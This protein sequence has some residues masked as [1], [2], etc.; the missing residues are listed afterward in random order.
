MVPFGFFL[1]SSKTEVSAVYFNP[2]AT[3][4]KLFADPFRNGHEKERVF[5]QWYM[6]STGTLHV[7]EAH[8]SN[9]R[10]TLAD[11]GYLFMNAHARHAIDPEPF[12]KQ[13]VAICTFKSDTRTLVSRTPTPFLKTRI[14][15]GVIP[16]D[17]PSDLL[18]KG[19]A[20]H[21]AE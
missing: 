15:L 10:E 18:V 8:P 21:N 6:V 17:Y 16:D 13:G 3:T 1:D 4:S 9:Y 19:K 2:R 12:F 7:N 5:A 20:I 11:G 14:A